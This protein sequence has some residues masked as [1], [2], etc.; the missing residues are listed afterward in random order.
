MFF[1]F[2]FWCW[3]GCQVRVSIPALQAL[4]LQVA[5]RALKLQLVRRTL[6]H[7]LVCRAPTPRPARQA[8]TPQPVRLVSGPL[9]ISGFVPL[10]GVLQLEPCARERV[11][12]SIL[13]LSGA[14]GHQAPAPQ[15]DRQ[16]PRD[17]PFVQHPAAGFASLGGD[18][19]T[20]AP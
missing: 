17:H 1:F 10:V 6:T 14:L 5:R 9:L 7:Q 3:K 18:T 19:V 8:L 13:P 16:V 2:F 11:L 20:Y 4:T 15:L 12:S